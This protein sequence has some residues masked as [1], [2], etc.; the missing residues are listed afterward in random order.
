MKEHIIQ[1]ISVGEYAKYE[2]NLNT[3]QDRVREWDKW[4][5]WRNISEEA[6][7]YYKAIEPEIFV[8]RNKKEKRKMNI[9]GKM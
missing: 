6:L 5:P 4:G 3:L 8:K 9:K 1:I 2:V 7:E